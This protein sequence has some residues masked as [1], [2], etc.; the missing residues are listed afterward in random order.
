M[1]NSGPAATNTSATSRFISSLELVIIAALIYGA[2]IGGFIPVSEVP[3]IVI[4]GWLSLRLRRQGGWRG[5]G[6]RAP[7]N[8]AL[9][10]IFALLAAV[11]LQLAAEYV[12]E[13]TVQHVTGARPDLSEFDSLVGNLPEALI[14]LA[15]VWVIAAFG[16]ELAY[17]GYALDRVASVLGKST[18]AY[19]AGVI[20]VSIAFGIGHFYQGLEGVISSTFSGLFFGAL[21][22][23]S[24]RNL[25]LPILAHGFTDTIAVFLIYSG[26]YEIT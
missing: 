18:G 7:K 21:Y 3:W 9:T 11:F 8:W 4:L 2:N 6:L 26:I 24:G 10:I 25:W 19:I 5:V 23:L 1:N 12:I 13:P 16:E 17:R 22:L 14:T 20:L 15:L